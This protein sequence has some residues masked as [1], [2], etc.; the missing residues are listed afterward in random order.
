MAVS[1]GGL[2]FKIADFIG[3]VNFSNGIAKTKFAILTFL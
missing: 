2:H 3:P 1:K